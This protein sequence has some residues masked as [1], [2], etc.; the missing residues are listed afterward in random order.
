MYTNEK[1]KTYTSEILKENKNTW[2]QFHKKNNKWK[3]WWHNFFN[4]ISFLYIFPN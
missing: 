3:K 2:S 4:E 1:L